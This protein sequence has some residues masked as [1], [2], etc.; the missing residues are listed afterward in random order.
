MEKSS[1]KDIMNS[2]E[3]NGHTNESLRR[4]KAKKAKVNHYETERYWGFE[5][6]FFIH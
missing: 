4:R 5:Q 3:A 1:Q 6:I 2:D